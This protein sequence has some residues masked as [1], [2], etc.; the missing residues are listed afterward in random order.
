M[1]NVPYDY[2]CIVAIDNFTG[3]GY[4]SLVLSL[5]S[6]IE[7]QQKYIE[8]CTNFVCWTDDY[9]GVQQCVGVVSGIS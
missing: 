7:Y 1:L 8:T 3:V 9:L 2:T 6:K 5:N 4:G